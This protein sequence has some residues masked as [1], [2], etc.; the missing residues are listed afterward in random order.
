MEKILA[1]KDTHKEFISNTYKQCVQCNIK[2]QTIQLKSQPK[3]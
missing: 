3:V 2:K 1:N